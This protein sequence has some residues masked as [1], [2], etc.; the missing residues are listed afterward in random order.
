MEYK[1]YLNFKYAFTFSSINYL[2][3]AVSFISTLLLARSISQTEFGYLS[4][5][6]VF[7]NSI[8]T[9]MQFGT[10]RT[11]VRD[12]VQQKEPDVF[13]WSAA[14]IWFVF[15]SIIS[16]A[17][18][19]WSFF[20]SDMGLHVAIIVTLCTIT[21]FTRGMSPIPWFDYKGKA[22]YQSLILLADRS[23]F[24]IA[25]IILLFFFRNGQVVLWI[26]II[27]LLIRFF[28]LAWEWKYVTKTAQVK[29]R[30]VFAVIKKVITSN[31]LVWVASLSSILIFQVNQLILDDKCGPAEMAVYG[32]AMQI[33]TILRLLQMQLARILSPSIANI[34]RKPYENSTVIRKKLIQYC[35]VNFFAS[36][37]IIIPVYFLAP[38]FIKVFIGKEYVASLAVLNILYIWALVSAVGIIINQFLISLHLQSYLFITSA[39]SGIL[40]V[41]LAYIFIDPFKAQGA[42]FSMLAAHL[43]SAVLQMIFIL[44]KIKKYSLQEREI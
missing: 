7:A 19:A 34:S 42:A 11:L 44:K 37:T 23:L 25:C 12:L 35:G 5:G 30:P 4:Y 13:L 39:G 36:S 40:A 14:W 20:F 32:I 17:I 27:Q 3:S 8:S 29:L 9:M 1:R 21:G 38:W 43:F 18:T 28:T 15:G 10:E 33:M 6:L 2:Q 22:N 26:C 31:T 41:I 24:L 16:L